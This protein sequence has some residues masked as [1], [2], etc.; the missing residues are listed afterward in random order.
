MFC[1]DESVN[2]LFHYSKMLVDEIALKKEK[3]ND[4]ILEQYLIFAGM[5]SYYG[6]EHIEAIYQAFSKTGFIK[7]YGLE[8]DVTHEVNQRRYDRT[9]FCEVAVLLYNNKYIVQRN[10]HYLHVPNEKYG[11]FFEKLVHE[12]NHC[13]NSALFPICYRNSSPVFRA[14]VAL[15]FLDNSKQKEGEYLEEAF[16][17]LQ[18]AEIMRHILAFGQYHI[19]DLSMQTVLER[20]KD[21]KPNKL[22]CGYETITPIIYPLYSHPEFSSLLKEDRISGDLKVIRSSF[23]QKVGEGSFTELASSI[24]DVWTSSNPKQLVKATRLVSNYFYR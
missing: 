8:E 15:S 6:F 17:T 13:V 23:E 12:I 20:L 11:D 5:L 7:T 21:R 14:G 22:G 9:S 19:D 10:I 16:N 24:D 1:S 4:Y 2:N 18:T 3:S